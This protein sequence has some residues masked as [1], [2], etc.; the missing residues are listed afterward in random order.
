MTPLA[1]LV[2]Y[3]VREMI[4]TEEQIAKILGPNWLVQDVQEIYRPARYQFDQEKTQ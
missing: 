3:L 2:G 1:R 4:L